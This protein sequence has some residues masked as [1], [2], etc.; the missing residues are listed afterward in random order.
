[1]MQKRNAM[2][3]FSISIALAAAAVLFYYWLAP[4]SVQS[5]AEESVESAIPAT[6]ESTHS[7]SRAPSKFAPERGIWPGLPPLATT[8]IEED[9]G[10]SRLSPDSTDTEDSSADD[11][12]ST[13]LELVEGFD[14][15][16]AEQRGR[17]AFRIAESW[18]ECSMYQP[19]TDERIDAHVERR[20]RN[21]FDFAT[22]ILAQEPEGPLVDEA[23][24]YMAG[25]D[26]DDVR[27]EIREDVLRKQQL[28]R[29][30]GAIDVR[31]GLDV[32]L[33]WLRKA[34]RLGN[35]RAQQR[36]LFEVFSSHRPAGQAAQIAEDK[37]LVLDIVSIMLQRREL[38][39]LERLAHFVGEGYF[40]PPDLMFAHAYGQAAILAAERL[41]QSPWH[42]SNPNPARVN[43]F[44]TMV[45]SNMRDVTQAL[46][47]SQLAEAED[48]ARKI[49]GLEVQP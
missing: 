11:E 17:V 25:V 37:Q 24:E 45:A 41:E 32:V 15:L 47:A 49:A 13:L 18:R 7:D 48:L 46:T 35:D 31:E 33:V 42:L 26:P 14:D 29:Y 16:S 43:Q 12:P 2:V 40:G 4:I 28:C 19:L 10:S 39:V 20:F 9:S 27:A 36:F 8:V 38:F 44:M 5:D 3:L 34:A 1:M 22:S 23:L 21:T 6:A 30:T